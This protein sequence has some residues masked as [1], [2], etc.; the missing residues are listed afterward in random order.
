MAGWNMPVEFVHNNF[1][2]GHIVQRDIVPGREW[3]VAL[4]HLVHFLVD[5]LLKNP[6]IQHFLYSPES[7]NLLFPGGKFLRF[8]VP[9]LFVRRKIPDFGVQ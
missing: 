7:V 6:E 2:F 1:G 8:E 4:N 3:V 5:I 9:E